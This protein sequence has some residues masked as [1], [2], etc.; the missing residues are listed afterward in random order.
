MDSHA[1]RVLEYDE[2]RRMLADYAASSLGREK[3]LSLEPSDHFRHIQTLLN[4]T[5]E[6]RQVIE[7]KGQL[8]LGGVTDV[9]PS[10][11]QASI[12][13]SLDAKQLL[14]IYN[15]AAASRNLKSFL[16]RSAADH[17]LMTELATGLGQFAA[18]E[19]DILSCIAPNGSVLDTASSDLNRIRSRKRVSSQRIHERLNS[20]VSGSMKSMLMDAVIVQRGERYCVPVKAEHRSAFGGI[21]HDTSASGGTLFMEP[22]AVVD[23]GN[24]IRELTVQETQEVA[25]ILARLTGSVGRVL[26]PLVTTVATM[27]EFDFISA[28]ANLAHAQHAAEPSVNQS[29]IVRLRSARHPLI[30]QDRCVPIDIDFGGTDKSVVLITGPNTGGKTVTLKTVG[31]LTLMAQS[32]LHVPAATAELNVFYQIFADIGDEQSVQQSLSTFSGHI[33]NI[34]QILRGV[35]KN[36]LVLLDELGAGTDPGEGAAIARAVIAKLLSTGSKVIATTH[37]GELKAYAFVTEGVQNASVEFDLASLSPTYRL[38]QGVPGSSNAFAISARLGMPEDVLTDARTNLTGS[39]STADLMEE[40]ERGRRQAHTDARDAERARI[41][42]QMLKRRYQDQLESLEAIRREEREKISDEARLVIKRAQARFDH[43]LAQVRLESTEG[44]RTE[45][46]REKVRQIGNDLQ[47]A[48]RNQ[49]E[50]V[51]V[52]EPVFEMSGLARRGDIAALTRLG[53][54]GEVLEDQRGDSPDSPVPVQVGS[55]RILVPASELRIIASESALPAR[56][57]IPQTPPAPSRQTH[58]EQS[59]A[60]NIAMRKAMEITPQ[61]TLLGQRAD[62][63]IQNVERYLDD[64]YAAGLERVRIVHGKG[65]GALRRAVQQHLNSHPLVSEFATA[66]PDEGGAGATVVMVRSR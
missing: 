41:E 29:G 46:A 56:N 66:N 38:M 4:Q 3:A 54:K 59:D 8:P 26:E 12:G 60:S 55:I 37:Y 45:R 30:A 57:D 47:H 65:S 44:R 7:S 35:R 5:T 42:A 11:A 16:V 1:I 24:E 48:L 10:L 62:E 61:I 31:L 25:R 50:P 21:V 19:S 27:A 64:A 53:M 6:C 36:S 20:I 22:Q 17:P 14:D 13:S 2:I 33:T 43:T 63:A 39:D 15:L 32:G 34:V 51:T 49:T 40:L 28:K 9:R 18:L 52:N 23:L 58:I